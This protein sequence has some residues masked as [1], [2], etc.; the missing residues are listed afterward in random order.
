MLAEDN[1]VNQKVAHKMLARFGYRVD[2]VS[3]G[4]EVVDSIN[5]VSYDVILMDCQMPEMDGYE[6]TRRIR[7]IQQDANLPPVR[8]IAMT[9]H[10]LQGDREK[11]LAAGMDDYLSKPVRPAELKQAL[12]RCHPAESTTDNV[13]PDAE[14][15]GTGVSPVLHTATVA[16]TEKS[17]LDEESLR[18]IAEGDPEGTIEL[19]QLYLDQAEETMRDL[20][21]AIDAGEAEPVNQ[22]AHRLAGASATCG[23]TAMVGPLREMERRG[24]EN[25]LADADELLD[26]IHGQL[27]TSRRDLENYI[28]ELQAQ[29]TGK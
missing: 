23:A 5:R 22:L 14:V 28:Q 1:P 15:G 29:P 26:H 11:C 10:A 13:A 12:E 3:N 27:E 24:R 21:T 8:I 18:D 4:L 16:S 9:A 20:Q 19:I 2:V 17:T 6:A 7:T 25:Q